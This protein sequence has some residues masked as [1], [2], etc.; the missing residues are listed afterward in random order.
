MTEGQYE[1][2]HE[3]RERLEEAITELVR[4]RLEGL[5]SEVEDHIRTLMTENYRFWR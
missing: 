4:K 5:P 2:A 3:I 1:V